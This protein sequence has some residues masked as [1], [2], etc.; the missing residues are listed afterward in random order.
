MNKEP[1]L[2]ERRKQIQLAVEKFVSLIRDVNGVI[3]V[4]LFGSAAS[5]KA[6]P[7]DFDLMVFIE[8]TDCISQVSK[9][10]R[11][12]SHIFHAHDVFVFDKNR[13]Y[14]GRICQRGT[15]PTSSVE[16]YVR[17]CGKIQYLKQI[18]GF[19]FKEKEAFIGKLVIVWLNP[20]QNESISQQWFNELVK[21]QKT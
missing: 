13:N 4:A 5:D 21:M 9:S 15:C 6:V 7:G 10:I 16:C 14:L 2:N 11:K 18:D 20:G 8:N 1:Y 3:E 19:V 12:T 17:D